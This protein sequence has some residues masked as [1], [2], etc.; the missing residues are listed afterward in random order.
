[1]TS[2]ILFCNLCESLNFKIDRWAG[3]AASWRCRAMPRFVSV[4][5]WLKL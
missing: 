4:D 5:P 3:A 2:A 1:M